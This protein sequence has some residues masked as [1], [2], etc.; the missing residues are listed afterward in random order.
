MSFGETNAVGDGLRQPRPRWPRDARA[1]RPRPASRGG[2]GRIAGSTVGTESHAA[3]AEHLVDRD[4]PRPRRR[5]GAS[6]APP[7]PRSLA[8][9]LHLRAPRTP[10]RARMPVA[11][12]NGTS[13]PSSAFIRRARSGCTRR[14][15]TGTPATIVPGTALAARELREQAGRVRQHVGHV[16]RVHPALEA[17]ARLGVDGVPPRRTAHAARRRST[18]TR[19]ARASSPRL[20]S[21]PSP[22]MTPA[23]ATGRLAVGDHQVVRDERALHAVERPELLALRRATHDD[24]R[25][26]ARRSKS[27]ACI[28]WPNSSITRFVTSTTFEMRRTRAASSR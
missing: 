20:I 24:A 2:C 8:L 6:A 11:S 5:A 7:R 28:G 12:V 15:A 18:R 21:L 19:A 25:R 22:P 16:R 26:R 17:V 13:T 9:A 10:A 1:P 14:P 3:D 23:S 4:R 27:N